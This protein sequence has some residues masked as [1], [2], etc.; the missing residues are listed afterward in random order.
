MVG[1]EVDEIKVG[2]HVAGLGPSN[3]GE[4]YF[5]NIGYSSKCLKRDKLEEKSGVNGS[6]GMGQ[7]L[8]ITSDRIYKVSKDLPYEEACYLEPVSTSIHGIRKLKIS[9]N[10]NVLVIGAGNL[11]LVNAQVARAYGGK[12]M[13]SEINNDRCEISKSLDFATINPLDTDFLGKTKDFTDDKGFDAVILAVGAT[14]ANEQA[15]QVL[16]QMGR[17]LFFAAGYPAPEMNIDPNT[18]HYN[19]YQ[20]IG[21]Y[22]ADQIDFQISSKLLSDGIIKTDKLISQRVSIDDVQKAFELA[23]TPGNYRVSLTMW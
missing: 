23:A 20:F 5:C 12:V 18:I 2:D 17:I 8:L 21:T 11:G 10:D 1:P 4:C 3:C 6:F 14:K 19:E 7:Y 9:P 13:V 22:R 16:G 15:L